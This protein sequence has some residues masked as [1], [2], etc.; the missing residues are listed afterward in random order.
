MAA[1]DDLI[2]QIPDKSLRDRIKKE[3]SRLQKNKKFGLVYEEH[4]PECTPLYDMKIKVGS[5]V[6]VKGQK[7]N[8]IFRVRKIDDNVAICSQLR[9]NKIKGIPT[10]NL[11]SIAEFGDPIYPYLKKIDSV[12]RAPKS[13][14]WHELI[15]ADNYHALQLLTYVYNGK[16]DCIYI[17]PPYLSLI[18][19]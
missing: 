19:I 2:N 9:T 4:L 6:A 11:I 7:I 18:H 10:K 13:N 1:I 15:E 14:L 8:N 5:K 16:V 17:D 12:S 3:T